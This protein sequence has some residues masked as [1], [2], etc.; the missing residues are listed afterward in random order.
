MIA[1]RR[2][3]IEPMIG[4][5]MR[6]P[7]I[8]L[9]VALTLAPAVPPGPF[10]RASAQAVQLVTVDVK[11]VAKGY[12]ATKLVGRSVANDKGERIGTIDD[13]VVGA[14]EPRVMFAILQIGGFLGLGGHLVA[15]PYESLRMDSSG[16]ITLPGASK[17]ELKRLPEF[18]YG[19][20]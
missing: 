14:D 19:V 8:T 17:E 4:G 18:F 9:A 12:R 5:F 6:K 10:Q 15:V 13:L 11:A 20:G 7:L 16:K 2:A 3:F 1:V